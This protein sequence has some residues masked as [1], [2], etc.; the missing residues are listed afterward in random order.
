MTKPLCF[1]VTD[2]LGLHIATQS[3]DGR[4]TRSHVLNFAECKA[5]VEQGIAQMQKLYVQEKCKCD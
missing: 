5:L 4:L 2:E 3:E 1:P